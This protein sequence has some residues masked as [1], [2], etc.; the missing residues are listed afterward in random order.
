MGGDNST[1]D[2]HDVWDYLQLFFVLD[3][4]LSKLDFDPAKCKDILFINDPVFGDKNHF[5]H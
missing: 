5:R 1:S 2:A 3:K 4:K